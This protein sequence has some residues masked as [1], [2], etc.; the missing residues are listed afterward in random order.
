MDS[1]GNIHWTQPWGNSAY[2]APHTAYDS[3]AAYWHG[4]CPVA[5]GG[6]LGFRPRI[7]TSNLTFTAPK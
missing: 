5:R 3:H 4:Q 7:D 1:E 6:G 2:A